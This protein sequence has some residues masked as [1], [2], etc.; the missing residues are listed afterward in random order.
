MLYQGISRPRRIGL[1]GLL[2]SLALMSFGKGNRYTLI[3]VIDIT[4]DL[5]AGLIFLSTTAFTK[6]GVPI[7]TTGIVSATSFSLALMS[8]TILLNVVTATLIT[9]RI[10]SHQRY[11]HKT[12]SSASDNSPYTMVLVICLESSA[13]VVVISSLF[14]ILSIVDR[15]CVM[16]P[17]QTLVHVYVRPSCRINFNSTK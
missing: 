1:V 12:T 5:A 10:I 7:T 9:L 17:M 3:F 4:V 13:L 2:V 15:A 14:L 6:V 11:I 8:I 16:I